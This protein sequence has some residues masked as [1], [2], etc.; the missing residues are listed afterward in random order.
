MST[1]STSHHGHGTPGVRCPRCG[2]TNLAA[3]AKPTIAVDHTGQAHCS[4]CG[5]KCVLVAYRRPAA[6]LSLI[7]AL[8]R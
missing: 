7:G 5:H 4:M 2:A 3:P 8:A 1:M 6:G